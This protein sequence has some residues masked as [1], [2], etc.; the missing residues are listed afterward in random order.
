MQLRKKIID[1]SIIENNVKTEGD[2]IAMMQRAAV[3]R[4]LARGNFVI[5]YHVQ[6]PAQVPQIPAGVTAELPSASPLA[7]TAI[8]TTAR[9]AA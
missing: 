9:P 4:A 8:D 2:L 6:A 7:L 1:K 3:R 5:H